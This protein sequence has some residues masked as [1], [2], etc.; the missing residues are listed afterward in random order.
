MLTHRKTLFISDLH[1]DES[2]MDMTQQ[3][4]QLLKNCDTTIDA[5]YI[6]GDL[7]EAWIGDDDDTLFHRNII[8]TLK[9]VTQ[10]GIPVYLMHGNRDFLIGKKFLS[11]T[12][13][14]LLPDEKKIML[15]GTPVLL[16]HG[17]TLCTRDIAYLKWRKKARNPIL[18]T[19]LFLILPL[20][21]RRRFANKM[22]AQSEY[23]TRSLSS[24]ILDV[25]QEEVVK[26]MQKHNV[27]VLIHG[28]THRPHIHHLTVN[29]LP[30][31]RIVL[32]AWHDQANVLVWDETG[33]KEYLKL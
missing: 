31:T 32:A 3:L 26:I 16:M 14:Q 9:S 22:R 19:L 4:L 28:H 30:A 21:I 6:L 20:N 1:L 2:R 8:E 10:K 33:K 15:Y 7:F 13:C 12:G 18:H 17:D 5:L 29:E 11:A 27:Q 23:H 24:D 25:T